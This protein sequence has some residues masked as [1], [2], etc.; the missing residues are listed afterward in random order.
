[1]EAMIARCLDNDPDNRPS[2]RELVDF[3]VELPLSLSLNG[4][5]LTSSCETVPAGKSAAVAGP[6]SCYSLERA[7]TLHTIRS[8]HDFISQD[9]DNIFQAY[10]QAYL[11]F[12]LILVDAV[13][14]V[15]MICMWAQLLAMQLQ[16]N[17]GVLAIG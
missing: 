9:T 15:G 1:M 10:I 8:L 6:S 13:T 14:H 11:S 7:L 2:A 17:S 12:Y 5:G 4:S 3:M 16:G